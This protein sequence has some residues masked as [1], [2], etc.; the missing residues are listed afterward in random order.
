[1]RRYALLPLFLLAACDRA[2]EPPKRGAANVADLSSAPAPAAAPATPGAPAPAPAGTITVKSASVVPAAPVAPVIKG[3]TANAATLGFA[4]R[5]PA[6]TEMFLTSAGMKSHRDALAK[7]EYFKALMAFAQDNKPSASKDNPIEMMDKYGVEDFFISFGEGSSDNV[8]WLQAV[9]SLYAEYTYYTLMSGVAKGPEGSK[10]AFGPQAII[11][12]LATNPEMVE[13]L[14]AAL[15]QMELPA[16]IVGAKT[17]QAAEFEK[18]LLSPPSTP[19]WMASVTKTTVAGPAGSTFTHYEAPVSTWLTAEMRE[20]AMK[21]VEQMLADKPATVAKIRDT[22]TKLAAKKVSLAHGILDGYTVLAMG[23]KPSHLQFA[24]TPAE[25]VLGRDDFTFA[26]PNAGKGVIGLFHADSKFLT[27]IQNTQPLSPALRGALNA[28]TASP[29]FSA[30]A[31]QLQP[32]LESYSAAEK[33]VNAYTFTN[34][35][36]VV[37]WDQGVHLDMSGGVTPKDLVLNKPLKFGALLDTPNAVITSV[38]HAPTAVAGRAYFESLMDLLYSAG[39]GL[40]GAGLGGDKSAGM[41]AMADGMVV[42][43]LV[44]I[45][46]ATK[47]LYQQGLGTESAFVLDMQGLMPQMAGGGAPPPGPA[48]TPFLPRFTFVHDVVSRPVL[49]QSWDQINAAIVEGLKASPQPIPLPPPTNS[50]KFGVTTWF[51]P[52]PFASNDILPSASVNDSVFLLGSSKALNESLAERLTQPATAPLTGSYFRLNFEAGRQFLKAL[53]V[54]PIPNPKPEEIKAVLPWLAPFQ[55][56]DAHVWQEGA[57]VRS[58]E[59]WKIK[60][61]VKYD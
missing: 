56:L 43:A 9:N 59:D 36:A 16:L 53:A 25:S 1:M 29:I 18:K 42:P 10:D 12:T 15:D 45:Y 34:A 2:P 20:Q 21:G 47:T 40:V 44:K 3:I 54:A 50:D 51:L 19:P 27:S 57:T 52:L 13:K 31:A 6:N 39:G 48:S 58:S 55:N 24:A 8:K 46:K 17:S 22:M 35:S 7:S 5:L 37:W 4:A 32:K 41:F 60:D 38:G 49:G 33:A 11:S 23:V 26:A 28:M 61:V 14:C 30:L